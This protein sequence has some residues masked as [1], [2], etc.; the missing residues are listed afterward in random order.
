M[1]LSPTGSGIRYGKFGTAG[2]PDLNRAGSADVPA[3]GEERQLRG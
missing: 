1:S 2:N 3:R